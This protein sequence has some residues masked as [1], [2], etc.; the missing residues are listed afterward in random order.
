MPYEP[1]AIRLARSF[2]AGAVIVALLVAAG[3]LV[4]SLGNM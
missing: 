1:R 2:S 4:G 3:I